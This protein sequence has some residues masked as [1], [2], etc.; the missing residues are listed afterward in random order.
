VSFSVEIATPQGAWS[1]ARATLID[2]PAH[3]GRLTVLEGHQPFVC[4]LRAGEARVREEEEAREQAWTVGPGTM[5]V[6]PGR[7]TLLVRHATLR[8]E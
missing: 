2:V 3:A 6:E 4:R 5:T 1:V 8:G 7:V